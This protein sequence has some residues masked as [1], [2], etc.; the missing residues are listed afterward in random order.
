MDEEL[1]A[2][3]KAKI[4]VENGCWLWQGG[5]NG[6]RNQPVI[7]FR[8]SLIIIRR[9]FYEELHG[10]IKSAYTRV[11]CGNPRCVNPE[12]VEIITA[13]SD[14]E[15]QRDYRIRKKTPSKINR[16]K[17]LARACGFRLVER[18]KGVYDVCLMS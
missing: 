10:D 15:R 7:R 1:L 6:V 2:R 12:H 17:A 5:M 11:T 13:K 3:I 14:R 16:L 4:V 8:G 18:A 9:A